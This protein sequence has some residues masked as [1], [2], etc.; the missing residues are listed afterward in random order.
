MR[1]AQILC[2]ATSIS[3]ADSQRNAALS[4]RRMVQACQD[5]ARFRPVQRQRAPARRQRR[6]GHIGS[7]SAMLGEMIQQA[8][9]E[10][11]GADEVEPRPRPCARWSFPARCGRA[12]F[13][14][15]VS[16][17]GRPSA[18]S[19]WRSAGPAGIGVRPLDQHLGEGG[20][21]HEAD[22]LAHGAHLGGTM[23]SPPC[24]GIRSDPPARRRPWRTSAGARSRR[25]LHAPRPWPSACRKAARV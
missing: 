9:F 4:S 19:G 1:K 25:P 3:C 5:I 18:A 16:V 13:S 11:G 6:D 7:P 21:I 8:L 15:W 14:M 12:R 22:P 2:P 17:I 20:D 23:S 24:G 10:K